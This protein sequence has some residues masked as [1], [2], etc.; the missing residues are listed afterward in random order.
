MRGTASLPDLQGL[1]AS[2]PVQSHRGRFPCNARPLNATPQCMPLICC[3]AGE[4]LNYTAI[5]FLT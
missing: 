1:E 5:Y 4:K 3:E 2:F